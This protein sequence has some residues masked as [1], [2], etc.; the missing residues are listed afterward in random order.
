MFNRFAAF[1]VLLALSVAHSDVTRAEVVS[2]QVLTGQINYQHA[3]PYSGQ[4]VSQQD[5]RLLPGSRVRIP[6]L[7]YETQSAQDGHFS[8]PALPDKPVIVSIEQPGYLPKTATLEKRSLTPG[9]PFQ[10]RLEAIATQQRRTVILDPGLYHLGDGSYSPTSAGAGAFKSTP[11]G[12]VFAKEFVLAGQLDT[13]TV[14]LGI[15]SVLG[16]DTPDAHQYGQS[17]F[18]HASS[19]MTVVLN[20]VPVGT[21]RLNGDGQYLRIPARLFRTQGQGLNHLE[22]ATGYRLGSETL[23][24]GVDYDDIELMLLTLTF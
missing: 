21:I 5:G 3:L 17:S 20:G 24:T 1:A 4:V 11:Q 7:G 16:L 14:T 12:P 9:K 18:H 6:A 19:P 10:V 23:Y 22:I 8:L 13:D 2:G 15:G